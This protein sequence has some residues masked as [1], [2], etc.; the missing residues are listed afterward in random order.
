MGERSANRAEWPHWGCAVAKAE[1][2]PTDEWLAEYSPRIDNV[3]AALDWAF[4]PNGDPAI[5]VALTAAAVPLWMHL[6]LLEEC[7]GRVEQA[8]AAVAA[9]AGRDAQRKVKLLAALGTS[10]VYT[11]G[12]VPEIGAA[13]TKAL[14][15][16]ESLGDTEYQL[17]SLFGLWFFHS[18]S[19][20]HRV[21]LTLAQRFHTLAAKRS[22]PDDR[23]IGERMIGTSQYYLGDLLSARH[24]LE[25]VPAHDVTPARTW[26]IVRFDGDQCAAARAYLARVLWLQGMPDQAMRTAESSVADARATNHATSLGLAL[27]R[28]ACPIALFTGNLAVAEHYVE[29]LLDHSTKHPLAR[30]R[31]RGFGYQGVLA[32]Q[33]GDLSS[34][35][36]SPATARRRG[37]SC[38]ALSIAS[39]RD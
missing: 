11:G 17:R 2:R 34:L 8:L 32:I 29:M 3:R 13:W 30:W 35:I 23:L 20:G 6:S 27:A 15:I 31:A 9:G 37:T 18:A 39:T 7:R 28:A 21:G 1:M 16:A 5:G 19:S 14:E 25:R 22:E 10:L 12:A 38:P 24:H 36:S 4:S 26:Q 33:R